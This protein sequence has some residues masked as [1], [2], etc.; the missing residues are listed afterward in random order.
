MS[1]E[2]EK[3]Q[4]QKTTGILDANQ[5]TAASA[6]T[7]FNAKDVTFDEDGFTRSCL[8]N[9]RQPC[10]IFI[11]KW[12]VKKKVLNRKEINPFEFL[13]GFRPHPP[14]RGD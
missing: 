10:S 8:S 6:L 1:R 9:R 5:I 3:T 12:Q 13:S 14:K 11:T 4:S 7:N 2:M